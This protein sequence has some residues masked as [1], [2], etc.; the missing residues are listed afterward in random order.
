MKPSPSNLY[1]QSV[2]CESPY[3]PKVYARED[4]LFT[5]YAEAA[6]EYRKRCGELAESLEA[7]AADLRDTAINFP[8]S[9]IAA[10]AWHRAQLARDYPINT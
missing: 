9:V 6:C 1:C 4:D 3:P 8:D 5:T 7:R 2:E 10:K